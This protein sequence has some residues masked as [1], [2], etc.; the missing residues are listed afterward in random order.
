[1]VLESLEKIFEKSPFSDPGE[2]DFFLKKSRFEDITYLKEVIPLSCYGFLT[3]F[4]EKNPSLVASECLKNIFKESTFG[5]LG[6]F[7]FFFQKIHVWDHFFETLKKW[8]ICPVMG[9]WQIP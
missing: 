7:D 4:L 3:N 8:S 9:P 5:S 2:L 1:M 6:K